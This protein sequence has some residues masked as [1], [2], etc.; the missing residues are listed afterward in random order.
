MMPLDETALSAT[1]SLASWLKKTE[2]PA[3]PHHCQR[4]PRAIRAQLVERAPALPAVAAGER[5]YVADRSRLAVGNP[6]IP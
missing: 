3:Q 2:R 1:V 4:V 6:K 5:L